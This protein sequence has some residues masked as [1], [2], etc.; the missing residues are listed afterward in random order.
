MSSDSINPRR[1]GLSSTRPS[2]IPKLST[3]RNSDMEGLSLCM[4]LFLFLVLE[5]GPTISVLRQMYLNV[6]EEMPLSVHSNFQKSSSRLTARP[7]SVLSR[8]LSHFFP[9]SVPNSMYPQHDKPQIDIHFYYARSPFKNK[10]QSAIGRLRF[11]SLRTPP[12]ITYTTSPFR[13][14]PYVPVSLVFDATSR[15]PHSHKKSGE[16]C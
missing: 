10:D 16:C 1:W 3:E 15:Q 7:R 9:L 14:L 13:S 6:I 12:H 11:R 5:Q 4:V 2:S 8:E